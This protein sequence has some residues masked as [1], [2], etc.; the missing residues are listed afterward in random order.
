MTLSAAEDGMNRAFEDVVMFGRPDQHVFD[1]Y[2]LMIS[3]ITMEDF[4]N[5]QE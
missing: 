2:R 5:E 3:I 4:L 1:Y